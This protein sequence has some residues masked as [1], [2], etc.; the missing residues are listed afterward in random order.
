MIFIIPIDFIY[1][2]LARP[3]CLIFWLRRATTTTVVYVHKFLVQSPS[4]HEPATNAILE[5]K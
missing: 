4:D 3:E 5:E 1:I 2:R